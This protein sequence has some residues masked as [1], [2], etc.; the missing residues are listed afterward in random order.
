MMHSG[1]RDESPEKFSLS[2][3]S[4]GFVG[5]LIRYRGH[6]AHA[7]GG[8]DRA[9]NALNAA[10]LGM[11]AIHANR[12][13]FADEDHVRVHPIMTRGGDLVNV[14]PSDARLET[15]VRGKT[16]EAVL[17]ASAK[18]DRALRA[19]A[20]AVGAEV[21]IET[22]PGYLPGEDNG[23]LNQLFQANVVRQFGE[24]EL[25]VKEHGAGSSDVGDLQHILPMIQPRMNGSE[26][27]FHGADYAL[28]DRELSYLWNGVMMAQ[29]AVDLLWDG[30]GEA[31]TVMERFTPKLT[32]AEYVAMLSDLAGTEG[33]GELDVPPPR[34][35][36]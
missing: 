25:R 14:V 10:M 32:R 17:R 34:G 7:A 30:A 27:A 33:F 2:S 5:K 4:N 20:M 3:T 31:R 13:T 15:Y 22:I 9:V 24:K 26:G 8:P 16:M 12:E 21:E 11:M 35:A 36:S 23:D 1:G 18:V 19:G 29:T 6:A 28:V